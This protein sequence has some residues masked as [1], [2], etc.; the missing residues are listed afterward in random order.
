M[1]IATDVSGLVVEETG[2]RLEEGTTSEVACSIIGGLA[3]LK[4][5]CERDAGESSGQ[6]VGDLNHGEVGLFGSDRSCKWREV[7][8]VDVG[9]VVFE[10][11]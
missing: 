9:I 2:E 8:V 4:R 11:Q 7:F 6:K 10:Y 5:C 3:V 1:N